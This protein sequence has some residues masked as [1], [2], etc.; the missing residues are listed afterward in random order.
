MCHPMF[1]HC[2]FATHR[3]LIFDN[4]WF[5]VKKISAFSDIPLTSNK[6]TFTYPQFH[7]E[8][9]WEGIPTNFILF[10]FFLPLHPNYPLQNSEYL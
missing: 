8:T 10:F 7:P 6:N 3:I 5:I 2:N 9:Q 1:G 4:C